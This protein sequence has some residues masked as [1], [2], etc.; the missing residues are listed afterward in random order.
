[1]N[2][3]CIR[4]LSKDFLE[5]I[6]SEFQKHANFPHALGGKNVHIRSDSML[7]NYKYYYSVVLMEVAD[8]IFRFV[9]V[10]IGS[11]GKYGEP[12]ISS[13]LLFGNQY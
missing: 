4:E 13:N 1:M 3:E 2:T 6:A 9:Y 11:F 8:L 5:T 10:N 12:S 7:F